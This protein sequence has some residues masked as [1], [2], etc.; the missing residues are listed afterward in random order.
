MGEQPVRL[1]DGSEFAFWEPGL[2]YTRTYHVSATDPGASDDG[3]GSAERPFRT[4][5]R[6]AEAMQPGERVVVG[7]GT[8]RERVCPPRGGSGPDRMIHYEAAPG[9]RVVIKGSEVIDPS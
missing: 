4:I 1:P 6:A 8:Y 9:A 7:A 2:D 5:Q 3:P